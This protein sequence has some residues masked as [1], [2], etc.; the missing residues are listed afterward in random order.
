MNISPGDLKLVDLLQGKVD[1]ASQGVL[2][3]TTDNNGNNFKDLFSQ[4]ATGK[5][6]ATVKNGNLS[7]DKALSNNDKNG[8]SSNLPLALGK[9][10]QLVGKMNSRNGANTGSDSKNLESKMTDLI[11]QLLSSIKGMNN[12]TNISKKQIIS[13][14]ATVDG[15]NDNNSSSSNNDVL[16][17]IALM[18][19]M[20]KM[21][22]SKGLNSNDNTSTNTS[23]MEQLLP[24][25]MLMLTKGDLSST[26]SMAGTKP[27]DK[28]SLNNVLQLM[29]TNLNGVTG[30]SIAS[31][32]DGTDSGGIDGG[33]IDNSG[34]TP[35]SEIDNSN[36]T[37]LLFSKLSDI[38]TSTSLTKE[39][40]S[41]TKLTKLSDILTKMLGAAQESGREQDKTNLAELQ[42]ILKNIINQVKQ[43][44]STGNGIDKTKLSE[45]LKGMKESVDLLSSEQDKTDFSK[46]SEILQ[47]STNS[48]KDNSTKVDVGKS[49]L[50]EE[51]LLKVLQELNK[52][53]SNNSDKLADVKATQSTTPVTGVA[54]SQKNTTAED[55]GNSLASIIEVVTNKLKAQEGKV[56]P[57]NLKQT[58]REIVGELQ[59]S[60][61]NENAVIIQ[62]TSQ[63]DIQAQKS[64][65]NV[66]SATP[67]SSEQTLKN[68][69]VNILVLLSS[70]GNT[71]ATSNKKADNLKK[72]TTIL[73]AQVNNKLPEEETLIKAVK[74]AS[75]GSENQD[76]F[77]AQ[78]ESTKMSKEDK[79][80]RDA[81][82]LTDDNS[83]ATK[84]NNFISQISNGTNIK[85]DAL[86]DKP[87]INRATFN[88][89]I[90]K[91]VKYMNTNDLKELSVKIAPGEM[92]EITIKLTMDQ[93]NVK[94]NISANTKDTYNLL[95]SNLKDLTNQLGSSEIKIH[96]L[97]ISIYQEDTTFFNQNNNQNQQQSNS[98]RSRNTNIESTDEITTIG[99]TEIK[100]DN[101]IS[102]LV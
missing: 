23:S 69:L 36:L 4:F 22:A 24:M 60:K 35:L 32:G 40:E 48:N 15:N 80:L 71:S 45:V 26:D 83:K 76:S 31:L 41:I 34:E 96:S 3:T 101:N 29:L 30:T 97:D 37:E 64:M 54:T 63:S 74:P 91:A 51:M 94:A 72:F 21:N 47:N 89:D 62:N 8:I 18:L 38:S 33:D 84:V 90:I 65:V 99:T 2:K 17:K 102:A 50:T 95:N 68:Q 55:I 81:A 58:Y 56:T 25:L 43:S 85:T 66:A 9:L 53:I 75:K 70:E 14:D 98:K 77:K 1:G 78:A 79:I 44:G 11:N 67:S 86:V 19:N 61:L 20:L 13:N 6:G 5:D 93:G 92:G 12:S 7:T 57:D 87:V 52:E 49:D 42:G 88:Q 28:S 16:D 73:D 39:N 46:L 27:T 59:L 82:K 10:K 100:D